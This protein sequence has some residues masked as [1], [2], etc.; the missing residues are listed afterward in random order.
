[1]DTNYIINKEI[2]E[3]IT[4]WPC[5]QKSEQLAFTIFNFKR[6]VILK[7]FTDSY[8]HHPQSS[9]SGNLIAYQAIDQ[10]LFSLLRAYG[11][12]GRIEKLDQ[13]F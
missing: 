13:S 4:C 6:Y 9:S 2:Q 3:M 12:S 7:A 8:P 11:L 5:I 10:R 1:M